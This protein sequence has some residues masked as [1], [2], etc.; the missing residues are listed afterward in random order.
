M[1]ELPKNVFAAVFRDKLCFPY[2]AA[3]DHWLRATSAEFGVRLVFA[4]SR[5]RPR[6]S[7]QFHSAILLPSVIEF[8]DLHR[9]VAT[10]WRIEVHTLTNMVISTDP[11]IEKYLSRRFRWRWDVDG[12][13]NGRGAEI[14]R[15]ER[16]RRTIWPYGAYECQP[17]RLDP[18]KIAVCCAEL[19]LAGSFEGAIIETLAKHPVPDFPYTKRYGPLDLQ[20]AADTFFE[21][22]SLATGP[23]S[24]LSRV[25]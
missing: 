12:N 20:A 15:Q 10:L 22:Y 25:D 16:R 5:A 17:H 11:R 24:A 3:L 14:V 19:G 13:L 6:L 8:G 21:K 1:P 4:P 9:L 18:S 23:G 7:K 2:A